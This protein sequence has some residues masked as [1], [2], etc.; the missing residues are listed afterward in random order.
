MRGV[1]SDTKVFALGGPFTGT[2][3]EGLK[4][5]ITKAILIKLGAYLKGKG[6]QLLVNQ[7]ELYCRGTI[8]SGEWTYAVD[9]CALY[10]EM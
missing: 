7:E 1:T 4:P 3:S 9:G 2:S 5:K 8:L 10:L 6:A